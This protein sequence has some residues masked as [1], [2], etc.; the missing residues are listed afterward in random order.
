MLRLIGLP[1]CENIYDGRLKIQQFLNEQN[2]IDDFD[3]I[4]QLA[5]EDASSSEEGSE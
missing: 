4:L 5:L 3:E 2:L 1:P